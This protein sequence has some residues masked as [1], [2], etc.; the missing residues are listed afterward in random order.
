MGASGASVFD[1]DQVSQHIG[2]FLR[3]AFAAELVLAVARW[4]CW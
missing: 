3:A 4:L 1:V 2:L